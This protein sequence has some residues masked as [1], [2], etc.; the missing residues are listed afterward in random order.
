[1]KLKSTLGFAA[2]LV[3]VVLAPIV[4]V[5]VLA[6]DPEASNTQNVP[7]A[8]R[9]WFV[10]NGFRHNF[11]FAVQEGKG[12]LFLAVFDFK[13]IKIFD[14]RS[15]LIWR[16]RIEEVDG[17]FKVVIAGVANVHTPKGVLKGWWFRAEARDID[18]SEKSGDSFSILVWRPGGADKV[19]C[20]TAKLFNPKDP[21]S[22][23]VNPIPFY[24]AFGRLRGGFVEI[25]P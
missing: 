12:Y 13:G 21:E 25:T 11:G 23:K 24:R 3:F 17:G 2:L 6:A 14:L 10:F 5:K 15:V 8:G 9:G 22:L 16:F 20:W 4:C 18:G 7:A 19:G 1:M